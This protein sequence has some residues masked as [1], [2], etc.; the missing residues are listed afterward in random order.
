VRGRTLVICRNL[1][2]DVGREV[3]DGDLPLQ[4]QRVGWIPDDAGQRG[5]VDLPPAYDADNSSSALHSAAFSSRLM[6]FPSLVLV[7]SPR[8]SGPRTIPVII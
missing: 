4:N 3:R 6:P 2:H 5:V 7:W 1:R 8:S